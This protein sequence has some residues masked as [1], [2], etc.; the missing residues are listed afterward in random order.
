MKQLL[1][2][3][4]ICAVLAGAT[5]SLALPPIHALPLIF[6]LSLAASALLKAR[7]TSAAF[8]LGWEQGLAGLSLHSTGSP[9]L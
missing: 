7:T 6:A 2:R 3:P 1:R 8:W 5:A 9:T 4:F